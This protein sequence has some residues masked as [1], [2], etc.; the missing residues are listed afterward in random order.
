MFPRGRA[1]IGTS[2]ARHYY[3][4]TNTGAPN[5]HELMGCVNVQ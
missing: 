2:D 4:A 5:T 3:T 1:L